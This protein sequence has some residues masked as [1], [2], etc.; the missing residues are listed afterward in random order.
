MLNKSIYLDHAATTPLDGEVLKEM[1]PYL[2]GVFGN[3]SSQHGYGR[4]ALNALNAA[5]EQ[6][7]SAFG[8]SPAEIYFTSG[9]TECANWAVKGALLPALSGGKHAVISA[10]EHPAVIQS[11][12]YAKKRGAD[13]TF[14]NPEE[15]GIINVNALKNALKKDTVFVAVMSANNETGA[16]QPVEEIGG[17]C[18]EN[19]IFYYCDCVQSAGVLPLEARNFT[20]AGI[21]AH[22]F[23]GPK[24]VG[25]MYLKSQTKLETLLC[26]GHQERGLRAGTV[27]VAGA[28][29]L[30]AALS[31][32][33][34]NLHEN[35][36][37]VEKLRNL[38]LDKVISEISGVYL[39][40]DKVRRLP[41]N[42]NLSF[43]GCDGANILM[44][45]DL[46]G[47]AA[48]TGSACSAGA[49]TLSQTLISMGLSEAR[50]RSAVRF[51]FGKD[52]N[53]SEVIIAAEA[54]KSAVSRIRGT[55]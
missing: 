18:R 21:S 11:A 12:L 35:N 54:L 23:Y 47:I 2:Q 40:G 19:K 3:P 26:G 6:V 27:N 29:G 30:A 1:T 24:G 34:K 46:A 7:A 38:F 50:A 53:D 52:N 17:F 20:A 42:A 25:A 39:N 4:E 8:C 33:I 36:I 49:A 22:K 16:L 15:N 32:S 37:K 5:R 28:V 10:M 43:D 41:S 51:T 31:K 14:L 45:L 48:S 13:V 55:K 44:L 9:G